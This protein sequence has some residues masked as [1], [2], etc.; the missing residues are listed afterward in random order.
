MVLLSEVMENRCGRPPNG[1]AIRARWKQTYGM[2]PKKSK[3]NRTKRKK[4]EPLYTLKILNFFYI[5]KIILCFGLSFQMFLMSEN[6]NKLSGDLG[7]SQKTSRYTLNFWIFE[8]FDIMICFALS[9]QMVFAFRAT[10]KKTCGMSPKQSKRV[11]TAIKRAASHSK[12]WFFFNF[13]IMLC[14]VFVITNWFDVIRRWWQIVVKR[15]V[16]SIQNS[17]KKNSQQYPFIVWNKNCFFK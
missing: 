12:I 16:Q 7:N 4:K 9:F 6:N 17:Q 11:K 1:F 2:S 8:I 13:N 10:W 15:R 14:F 5:V 3:I